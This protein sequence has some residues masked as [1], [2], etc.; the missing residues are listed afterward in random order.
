MTAVDMV[1]RAA[2]PSFIRLQTS[3]GRRDFE[4]TGP[5]PPPAVLHHAVGRETG[6]DVILDDPAKVEQ[7][8]TV[9]DVTE[10]W[11]VSASAITDEQIAGMSHVARGALYQSA[12]VGEDTTE[13]RTP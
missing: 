6:F 1:R 13:E 12:A 5:W 10:Y 8:S 11:R 7:A 9:A 4:W 2:G 3:N